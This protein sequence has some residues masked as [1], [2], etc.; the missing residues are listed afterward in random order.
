M[1][2]YEEIGGT[3]GFVTIRATRVLDEDADTLNLR[4]GNRALAELSWQRSP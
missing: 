2:L 3:Q 4:C 1:P